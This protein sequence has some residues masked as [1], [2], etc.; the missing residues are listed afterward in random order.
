MILKERNI[1]FTGNIKGGDENVKLFIILLLLFNIVMLIIQ[2]YQILDLKERL[3]Q[4]KLD[5]IKEI[6]ILRNGEK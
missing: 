6:N 1:S 4:A 3:H 5:A 2:Q